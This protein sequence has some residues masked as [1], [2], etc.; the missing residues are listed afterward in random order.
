MNILIDANLS[1]RL[2]KLLETA[3]FSN[4]L[5]VERTGLP[6]PATD[7]EIWEWAK[8]NGYLIVTNDEDFLNLSIQKGYPP[9]VILLKMGNQ[10]TSY[11]SQV[12]LKHESSIAAFFSDLRN[13]VLE[14][15]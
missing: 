9:K 11:I 14:L 1:W 4:V 2:V 15:H 8:S 10:S 3:T 13:G 6:I 5:H 7:L 12:L